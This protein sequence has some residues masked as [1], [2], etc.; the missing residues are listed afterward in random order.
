MESLQYLFYFIIF[1]PGV[2]SRLIYF[3]TDIDNSNNHDV[4]KR[5]SSDSCG[6]QE[7]IRLSGVGLDEIPKNFVISNAIKRINL[8]NNE[9]VDIPTGMFDDVQQLECLNLA[10]NKIPLQRFFDFK[11]DGLKTLILDHQKNFTGLNFYFLDSHNTQSWKMRPNLPKLENLHMNGMYSYEYY[12]QFNN[13]FLSLRKLYLTDNRLKSHDMA[14]IFATLPVNV[15]SLHLERNK[16]STV[17]LQWFGN[18]DSLHLDENPLSDI[19]IKSNALKLLSLKNCSFYALTEY[20]FTIFAP[21]LQILD[22]SSNQIKTINSNVFSNM[23]VLEV[24]SLDRNT[25][26]TIPYLRSLERLERLSLAYNQIEQVTASMLP[27]TLRRLDLQGNRI[28][29]IDEDTFASLGYLEELDLSHNELRVLPAGWSM[30]LEMLTY[31][32][33]KANQLNNISDMS[34][35]FLTNLKELYIKDNQITSIDLPALQLVPEGCTVYV[36]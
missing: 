22:L 34:I 23:P 21:S 33:V 30:N 15:E 20:L 10:W 5:L 1:V 28:S 14:N 35:E 3:G 16:I 11:H 36:V 17:D 32:N 4:I 13:S 12:K 26:S 9:L 25:L 18:L 29:N 31:L 19:S 6:G 2:L 8:E 24:L 27:G 7:S